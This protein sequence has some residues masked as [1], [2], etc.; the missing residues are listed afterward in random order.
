MGKYYC[1]FCRFYCN[2]EKNDKYHCDKC[3]FCKAGI[4]EKTFHCDVC[5]C[6]MDIEWENNHTCAKDALK[7]NCPVCMEDMS[8]ASEEV[9]FLNC[10]HTIHTSCLSRLMR[11]TNKCPICKKSILN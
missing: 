8:D 2:N 4:K 11:T 6:C 3:N 5:E 7:N 10:N 9:V 1:K